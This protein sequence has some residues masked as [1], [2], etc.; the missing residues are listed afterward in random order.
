MTGST[1]TTT[2]N[3]V[4]MRSE[5]INLAKMIKMMIEMRGTIIEM[6]ERIGW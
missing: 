4:T 2:R 5:R 6:I 3:P 1:E